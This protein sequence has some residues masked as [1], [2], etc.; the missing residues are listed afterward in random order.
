MAYVT[1]SMQGVRQITPL[2]SR[3]LRESENYDG[4]AKEALQL[5][6][7]E[8]G[9][10]EVKRGTPNNLTR[11]SE[12]AAKRAIM[13]GQKMSIQGDFNPN[14]IV[15]PLRQEFFNSMGGMPQFQQEAILDKYSDNMRQ[16]RMLNQAEQKSYLELREA[17]RKARFTQAADALQIPVSRRIE[18]IMSSGVKDKNK[19]ESLQQ[20]LF[21]NPEAL[22]NPLVATLYQTAFKNV[23]EKIDAKT[24]KKNVRDAQEYNM[25][26]QAAASGNT[27]FINYLKSNKGKGSSK[28]FNT[29]ITL[30][31]ANKQ[32]KEKTAY[33]K[34][35]DSALT[36]AK[37][38]LNS[39]TAIGKMPP[40]T[41]LQGI[42]F[43]AYKNILLKKQ[44][45]IAVDKE[46]EA[47]ANFVKTAK[48]LLSAEDDFEADTEGVRDLIKLIV[49]AGINDEALT[50]L[51]G[52]DAKK[53]K[54]VSNY[55]DLIVL[56]ESASNILAMKG[57]APNAVMQ[58]EADAE[59]DFNR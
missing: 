49:R 26:S 44:Q 51:L 12:S 56:L 31:E 34:Q 1:R 18:E 55:T 50:S 27:E 19:F 41:K 52:E 24:K 17:Q 7:A 16:Q 13:A 54:D 46:T 53:L 9:L 28:K 47:L 14:D 43:D 42:E 4:K 33:V 39:L 29:A 57:S 3:I 22:G 48:F 10:F 30:A 21:E 8:E 38:D 59:A 25:M 6:A 37:E 45:G 20:T 35:Y 23:G 2:S 5:K 15:S 11:E 58:A 32:A 40:P 36:A